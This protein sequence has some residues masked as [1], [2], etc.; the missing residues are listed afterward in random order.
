MRILVAGATGV[1]GRTLL[2]CLIAKGYRVVGTT[3]TESKIGFIRRMGGEAIVMN[4][5]DRDAVRR[6][7]EIARPEVIIHEMTDLSG[8]SDLLRFDRAFAVSNRLRTEGTDYLL[9]AAKEMGVKRLVA[10]SFCGWPFARFGSAVKSEAD[11]LDA[12]PPK[13]LRRT[14]E[15][16]SHL[17]KVVTEAPGIEGVVLR[18]GA[19]YGHDTGLFGAPFLDQVRRR[20]VPII[21]DGSGWWSLVHIEDVAGATALAVERGKGGQIYNIVDDEPARVRD[22]LPTLAGII[23]ARPPR[24]VP[25]WLGR[26]VAGEHLVVMMTEARAGSNAKAKRDLQWQPAQSSWR[27]GFADVLQQGTARDVAA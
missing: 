21:G 18:Y 1:V 22:W 16:I 2:P 17:E 7:V 27:Q 11:P 6:A 20:R 5:L 10:Q 13:E 14:L 25:R 26:L 8:I 12:E 23:G 9:A 24:H 4:G 3:R 19:F 15:A